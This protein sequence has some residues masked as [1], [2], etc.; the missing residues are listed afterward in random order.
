MNNRIH[1]N[2]HP[3]PQNLH[4]KF[5]NPPIEGWDKIKSCGAQPRMINPRSLILCS[6]PLPDSHS[7][8]SLSL[9]PD[10]ITHMNG[11]FEASRANPSSMSCGVFTRTRLPKQE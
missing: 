1:P 3:N 5:L 2:T 9:S 4:H 6:Y 8:T 7:S 11:W 10:L